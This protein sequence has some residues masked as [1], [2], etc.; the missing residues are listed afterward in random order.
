MEHI[1]SLIVFFPLIA[2]MFGFVINKESVKTF[3]I[4]VAFV[5]FLLSIILWIA[6]DPTNGGFQFVEYATLIPQ[7]GVSFYLGVDGISLFLVILSTFMTLVSLIAL[8]IKKDIKNLVITVLFLEMTLIGVFLSLDMIL[9]Y[10]FWEL[11][12]IPMLYIIGAW[13][14]GQ[15]I[16]AAIKFFL[17]TFAGSALMLVGILYLGYQYYLATG[18]WSFAVPDWYLLV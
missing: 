1:L 5:E 13:G 16:Y 11:S 17:Y 15:R 3:G 10:I 14:S 7:F 4:T 2:G 12:L 6:Y 8:N 18:T 9:F